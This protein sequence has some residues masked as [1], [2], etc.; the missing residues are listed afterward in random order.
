M[1]DCF[2]ATGV[3]QQ[4]KCE[5]QTLSIVDPRFHLYGSI[6]LLPLIYYL[7]QH[8]LS[9]R[10]NDIAVFALSCNV[11]CFLVSAACHQAFNSRNDRT[12]LY[13]RLDYVGIVLYIWATSLSVLLLE[14]DDYDVGRSGSFGLTLAGLIAA[15]CLLF[16]PHGKKTRTA[17][18]CGFGTLAFLSVMLLIAYYSCFSLLSASF[19][20]MVTINC[21]GGWH[22]LRES[23]GCVQGRVT[24]S[25]SCEGHLSMHMCSVCASVIHGLVLVYFVTHRE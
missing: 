17:F 3:A 13:F 18:I 20:M 1:E 14:I 21:V 22:Y 25:P 11:I 5:S 19:S 6:L 15:A 12:S 24:G 7:L 2:T 9:G 10:D 4:P 8:P 16:L 23:G